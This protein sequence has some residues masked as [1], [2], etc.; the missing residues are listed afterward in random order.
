MN[1]LKLKKPLAFVQVLAQNIFQFIT[2]SLSPFFARLN[3]WWMTFYLRVKMSIL[4][5]SSRRRVSEVR[6]MMTLNL[7]E[8]QASRRG[9]RAILVAPLALAI[10]ACKRPHKFSFA[11]WVYYVYAYMGSNGSLATEI[12]ILVPDGCIN[13]AIFE[14]RELKLVLRELDQL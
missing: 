9:T 10:Y 7:A 1:I 13:R 12:L 6:W 2:Q 5:L 8:R 14:K 11:K 3:K 4:S